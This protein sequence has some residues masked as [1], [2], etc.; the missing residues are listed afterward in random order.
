M[1]LMSGGE[2]R[3]AK[4]E[5]KGMRQRGRCWKEKFRDLEKF[6]RQRELGKSGDSEKMRRMQIGSLKAKEEFK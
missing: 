6:L 5:K 1:G 4:K 2:S 3:F